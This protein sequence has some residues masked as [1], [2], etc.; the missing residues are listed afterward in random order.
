MC[1]I[2]T[3]LDAS[4][5]EGQT[6]LKRSG[7]TRSG[8]KE[9]KSLSFTNRS[10]LATFSAPTLAT[11]FSF[12]SRLNIDSDKDGVDPTK[13]VQTKR[14][15]LFDDILIFY[16]AQLKGKNA[17]EPVNTNKTRMTLPRLINNNDDGIKKKKKDTY[18]LVCDDLRYPTK[19]FVAMRLFSQYL[20]PQ[21]AFVDRKPTPT[22]TTSTRLLPSTQLASTAITKSTCT[23]SLQCTHK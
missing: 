14:H 7:P 5:K 21:F 9:R 1:V 20:P 3:N 13:R 18:F 22:P 2:T 16:Q 12:C 19:C 6:S 4:S 10:W 23:A 11:S 17:T 8:K 15:F